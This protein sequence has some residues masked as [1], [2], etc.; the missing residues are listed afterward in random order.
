M[1]ESRTVLHFPTVGSF[2]IMNNYSIARS[3]DMRDIVPALG[4][5]RAGSRRRICG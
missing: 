3:R 1:T 5:S 2:M 4:D